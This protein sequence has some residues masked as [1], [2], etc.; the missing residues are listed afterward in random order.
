MDYVKDELGGFTLTE[1][2]TV[3]VSVVNVIIRDVC[4]IFIKLIGFHTE[5]AET[6]AVMTLITV[7]TFFNTAVLMLLSNANTENTIL[8]WIPLRGA[9]T[10]LNSDW[11]SLVGDAIVYTMLINSVMIYTGF[12]SQLGIKALLRSLD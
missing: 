11:Y 7:A 3:I 2:I 8:S 10:D 1:I 12:I 5:T 9:Y 6:A 4:I